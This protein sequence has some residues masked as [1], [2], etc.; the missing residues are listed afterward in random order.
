MHAFRA[1]EGRTRRLDGLV[2][3]IS[4]TAVILI[5][6]LVF[7]AFVVT[8]THMFHMAHSRRTQESQNNEWL[9]QQCQSA[10]FYSSMKHHSTLC[11]DVMLANSDSI[12]LH[13]LRDVV[14]NTYVCG[15]ESCER[16]VQ[17]A[18]NWIV[19]KGLFFLGSVAVI[20]L[21]LMLTAVHL[22]RQLAGTTAYQP[23][24]HSKQIQHYT[25]Q[26]RQH[27]LLLH[28]DVYDM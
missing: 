17:Q 13:A 6:A 28:S 25:A 4:F 11:D 10:E 5:C 23:S 2:C 22:Q 20:V 8:R 26:S 14:D 27:P 18:F 24:L 15:T 1:H 7:S 19:G 9:L 3:N 12:W 21:M 16:R